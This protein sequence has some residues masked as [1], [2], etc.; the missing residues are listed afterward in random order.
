MFQITIEIVSN[1]TDDLDIQGRNENLARKP[2]NINV[3]RYAAPQLALVLANRYDC[4][5]K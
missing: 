4:D 5:I 2:A 3:S 1:Y